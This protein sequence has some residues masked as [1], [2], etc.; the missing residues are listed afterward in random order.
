MQHVINRELVVGAVVA[1]IDEREFI[2][3]FNAQ[4]DGAGARAGFAWDE[5]SFDSFVLQEFQ[6][7]IADRIIAHGSEHR[8]AQAESL[9]ADGDIR[10]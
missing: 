4:H 9:N 10:R 6:Y 5:P 2:R 3:R 7:E 1:V 8:R